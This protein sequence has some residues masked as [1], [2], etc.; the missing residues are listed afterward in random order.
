MQKIYWDSVEYNNTPFFFTIT[1][2]GLNF[3]GSPDKPLSEFFDFYPNAKFTSEFLNDS[4]KT[5]EYVDQFKD[6][7]EGKSKRFDLPIDYDYVGGTDFQREVWQELT[8]IPYGKTKT[9]SEIA[10]EISKPKASRAVGHAVALNPLLIV[11]PCHR[12]VREDGSLGGYRGGEKQK[13]ALLSLESTAPV[14][15]SLIKK[16]PLPKLSELGRPDL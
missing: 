2:K 11:I 3:V 9:Y 5:D 1:D 13:K 10:D 4:D 14:R 8:N 16:L 7:F 12:V 15:K 6:Y